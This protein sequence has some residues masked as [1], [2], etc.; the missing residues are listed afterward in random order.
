VHGPLAVLNNDL[1]QRSTVKGCP[2]TPAPLDIEQVF[3]YTPDMTPE[4]LERLRRSVVMVQSSTVGPM[5]KQAALELIQE[6]I[7][8]RA[9]SDRY[10]A[11]VNKLKTLLDELD[12][13]SIRE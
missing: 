1:P 10:Q 3:V 5:T 9:V 7:A 13:Q 11:V 2:G 4:D 12:E 8:T 6:A